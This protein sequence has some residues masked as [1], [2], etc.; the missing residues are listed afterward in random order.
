[1]SKE[2]VRQFLITNGFQ[3]EDG[4]D[5]PEFSS[6]WIN[7]VS[8]RYIELY[9]KLTGSTFIPAESKYIPARIENNVRNFLSKLGEL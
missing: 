9:E 3:G 6:D 1:M 7:S 4:Q 5:I 2:F 8:S